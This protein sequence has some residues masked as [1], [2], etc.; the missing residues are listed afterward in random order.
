M[1]ALE[2]V[3]DAGKGPKNSGGMWFSAFPIAAAL[4]EP[5]RLQSGYNPITAADEKIALP[6]VQVNSKPQY[7]VFALQIP[8][9][10]AKYGHL[11]VESCKPPCAKR[12][13]PCFLH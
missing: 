5:S 10:I 12:F 8:H 11:A 3:G 6:V 13:S 9:H 1:E 2:L 4:K 7:L